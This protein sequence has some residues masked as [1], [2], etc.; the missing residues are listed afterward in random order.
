MRHHKNGHA[1]RHAVA[2]EQ[3]LAM[4][5]KSFQQEV[6]AVALLQSGSMPCKSMTVP[7]P[8]HRSPQRESKF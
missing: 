8:E 6:A 5:T 3:R 7:C 2:W 1:V 4:V